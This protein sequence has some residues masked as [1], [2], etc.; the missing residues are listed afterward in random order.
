MIY[1]DFFTFSLTIITKTVFGVSG[2]AITRKYLDKLVDLATTVGNSALS[3]EYNSLFKLSK[4]HVM[5]KGPERQNVPLAVELMSH[6]VAVNLVRHFGEFE[7]ARL[8]AEIINIVD[9]WFNLMNSNNPCENVSSKKCFG[10]DLDAQ[11]KILN[12]MELLMASIR[13]LNDQGGPVRS[14]RVRNLVLKF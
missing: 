1:C 11:N 14:S 4:K 3:S 7:E 6:T 9:S 12:D 13:T 10:L 5:C 8:L 2:K